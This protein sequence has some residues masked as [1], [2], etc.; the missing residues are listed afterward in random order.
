MDDVQ[1]QGVQSH[2]NFIYELDQNNGTVNSNEVH[3]TDIYLQTQSTKRNHTLAT[4]DR[5]FR[6]SIHHLQNKNV[7]DEQIVID[8]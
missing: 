3:S 5:L 4:S 6:Q 7:Q 2:S 1:T 8:L